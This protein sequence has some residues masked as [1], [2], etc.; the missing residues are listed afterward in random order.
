MTEPKKVRESKKPFNKYREILEKREAAKGGRHVHGG[1]RSVL[2]FSS[3]EIERLVSDLAS[4][5]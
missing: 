4:L 1:G 2:E 5:C 3:V